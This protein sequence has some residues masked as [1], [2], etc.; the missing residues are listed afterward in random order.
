[1]GSHSSSPIKAPEPAGG[2]QSAGP[3]KAPGMSLDGPVAQLAELAENSA[4]VRSLSALQRAADG[5]V[6]QRAKLG[7]LPR[8][9][10]LV[11]FQG[12]VYRVVLTRST[13]TI[14]LG[15]NQV[16]IECVSVPTRGAQN[17][18][19]SNLDNGKT[20]P[21][22]EKDVLDQWL[23]PDVLPGFL[24]TERATNLDYADDFGEDDRAGVKEA[25]NEFYD[26]LKNRQMLD[27][28][29][30][31]TDEHF[32]K[33]K[34]KMRKNIRE[35]TGLSKGKTTAP[36]G[37]RSEG[38]QTVIDEVKTI[39]NAYTEEIRTTLGN[40]AVNIGFRGSLATGWKNYKK[41]VDD[42]PTPFST[43][44]TWDVD[45]FLEVPDDSGLTDE[46]VKDHF[47]IREIQREIHTSLSDLAGYDTDGHF[48][49]YVRTSS[50]KSSLVNEGNP[51]RPGMMA[52][53]GRRKSELLRPARYDDDGGRLR[54]DK[55][56]WTVFPEINQDVTV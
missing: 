40:D 26:S 53:I 7:S 35:K 45:A 46:T 1:M 11:V 51:Y 27:S 39:I 41:A 12:A 22:P 20:D 17:T 56:A 24:E 21:S 54:G 10:T 52:R 47:R 18:G 38:D 37:A 15:K 9:N 23:N 33:R 48:S 49:F 34:N 31:N 16:R 44:V 2:R 19:W 32:V 8:V 42:A 25:I 14:K 28:M 13:N 30:A 4:P 43:D 6:V 5:G 36:E 29:G 55:M 50:A 3:A